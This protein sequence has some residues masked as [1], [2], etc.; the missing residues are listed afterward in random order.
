MK[1]NVLLAL[2]SSFL[3]WLAWPPISYTSPLLLVAFVPLLFALENIISGNYT[4]KGKK[5]FLIAGLTGFIWNTASIYWV[6][7][8]MNA[9]MPS[10]VA[11]II[12]LIP[13]GLAALL[14]ALAFCLYYQL[15]KRYSLAISFMGLIS[16]WISYEFLH[17]S[18][19]L[20]FPWMTLGNG[21]SMDHHLV[22]WYEFTGVF[23]GS[24]W[25]LMSNILLFSILKVG[26]PLLRNANKKIVA[27]WLLII[28]VP[29]SISLTRYYNYEER[30]NPTDIVVVQPNVDPYQKY[31]DLSTEIQLTNLIRLSDSVALPN[32]EFFIWPETAIPEAINEQHIRES[33]SFHQIQ[34]FLDRYKNG[35]RKS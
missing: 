22:Q 12:S 14:M 10:V 33:T 20:A 9:V 18:W 17:Q 15:R 13:F 11:I 25:I 28:I 2:L 21:F 27:A 1:K 26:Q 19:D 31:G 4:K 3:L 24:L 6:F 35:D 32:T 34:R 16:F 5:V 7:N 30:I 29:T 23:G 8:A